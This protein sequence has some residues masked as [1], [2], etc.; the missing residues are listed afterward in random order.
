MI[1]T[2]KYLLEYLKFFDK[3]CRENDIEYFLGGGTLLGAIRHQGFLPWD[4]DVDLYVKDAEWERTIEVFRKKLPDRYRV[5]SREI[6]P[7]YHNSIIRIVDT[8]TSAFYK[9]RLA[10]NTEHG[11]QI[12]LFRL[13][14]IQDVRITSSFYRD[15]WTYTEAENPYLILSDGKLDYSKFSHQEYL[16]LEKAFREGS[17][18][19]IE[20]ARKKIKFN[21]KD[22]QYYHLDWEQYWLTFPI[23]AFKSQLYVPFEDTVFP[24]PVGYCDVLFGEYGDT[25]MEIPKVAN[26]AFHDNMENY[27][28]PYSYMEQTI[29]AQMNKTRHLKALRDRKLI[30]V[31]REFLFFEQTRRKHQ[32]QNKHLAQYYEKKEVRE[33]IE[34][35]FLSGNWRRVL[36]L[37]QSLRDRQWEAF[38]NNYVYI[39]DADLMYFI[40][41]SSLMQ[42]E[43][44]YIARVEQYME[45]E[46]D[47][48]IREIFDDLRLLRQMRFS[49][50]YD[51]MEEFR[52]THRAMLTK[53]PE[54]LQ[55]G[56]LDVIYRMK[57]GENIEGLL[58]EVRSM[59]VQHGKT[60]RLEKLKAELL[61][62]QGDEESVRMG[63]MI[64]DDLL[65]NSNDGMVINEIRGRIK[66]SESHLVQANPSEQE[67][68]LAYIGRDYGKCLYLYLDFVKYGFD[69]PNVNLWLQKDMTGKN[70]ALILQYY[71]GMHIYSKDGDFNPVEIAQLIEQRKP[72]L[73]Y[74][75]EETL[76]KL[77]KIQGY[78]IT[79]G[80]VAQ[81]KEPTNVVSIACHKATRDEIREIADLLATEES[82]NNNYPGDQL[83]REML[84]RFDQNF[85]RSFYIRDEETGK[86]IATASTYAEEAGV[87]VIGGVLVDS[88]R[89]GQ[90]LGIEIETALCK[91]LID[92]G[93]DVFLYYYEE[94]ASKLHKKIGFKPLGGWAKL[95]RK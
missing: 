81:M 90:G 94:V 34:Q 9:S 89:R 93:Y 60:P 49:Y 44:K 54:Q 3:F 70:L 91:D 2:Q 79:I 45:D 83:Y 24:V 18:E 86:V 77:G 31:E 35:A 47:S 80:Y 84:E 42:G 67:E 14:P 87:A 65:C 4:D 92:D 20:T 58:A 12:E 69:N 8:K 22:C 50:Y 82:F 15:Y 63:E 11:V 23:E 48:R 32:L 71:T 74:G 72:S 59:E 43:Y 36:E 17:K 28:I 19:T 73:I 75:M 55:L 27:D 29:E 51:N 53:Y 25:W 46:P 37:S 30:F 7:Q 78:D 38:A 10:D 1:E 68:I 56:I 62:R 52:D 33:D 57:D 40:L 13:Q 76:A 64:L 16:R 41:Y 66:E 26:R 5:V 21:E 61:I 85:G 6:S 88:T 39:I 95:V